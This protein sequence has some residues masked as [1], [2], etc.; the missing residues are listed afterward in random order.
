MLDIIL[1]TIISL[2]NSK[3]RR[4]LIHEK[5][6]DAPNNPANGNVRSKDFIN[7]GET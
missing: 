2:A 6:T 4:S 5:R 1:K 7:A 3:M